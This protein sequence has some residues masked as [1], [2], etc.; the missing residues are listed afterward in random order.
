[1]KAALIASLLAGL[2]TGLGGLLIALFPRV[3]RRMYD[4]LLGFSA[5]VM[6]AAGSITLLWPALSRKGFVPVTAG[7][8]LGA[9]LV[10]LLELA[11]PHLEPHFAPEVVNCR[12]K[13]LGLMMAAALTLHHVPEGLAIG[14]AFAS[15][16]R[17]LGMIVAVAIALQNIPEG[18]AVA[19]P[20]RAAGCSRARAIAWASLSGLTEPI[21]AALG[22]WFASFLNG[23]LPFGMALAA[24]AMIFVASD[25]LIPESH[26]QSTSKS[27]SLGL[28]SG[29]V[30]LAVL[31]K[32]A[33]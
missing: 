7:L 26:A 13:R 2:A 24:G 30:L 9:L 19:M 22:V 15:E 32:L 10:Y 11:V 29:F 18:L 20:L 3:S 1:M 14:V 16:P 28:I 23:M 4:T 17:A 33:F 12:S 21:A 8:L 27:P 5:G 31:T 6:L 25:Q